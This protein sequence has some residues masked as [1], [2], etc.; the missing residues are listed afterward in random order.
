MGIAGAVAGYMIPAAASKI[1]TYKCRQKGLSPEEK[2]SYIALPLTVAVTVSNAGLWF[3]SALGTYHILQGISMSLLFSLA[4]LVS[5]IDLRIRLIP[6]ELVL[7]MFAAGA[8]Y[9]LTFYGIGALLPSLLMALGMMT[10]FSAA[11]GFAGFNKVGA[12]DIKL[13]GAMGFSLGFPSVLTAL[14]AMSAALLIYSL[15]G[16]ASKKLTLKS[17][18]PFAPFMML[19]L[20]AS[21]IRTACAF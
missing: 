1:S 6:N 4:I 11:A 18:F 17:A 21:L 16:L 13:A 19:G 2:P 10:L 7:A 12:G 9:K 8:L 14:A 15:G 3:L 20:A 5:L